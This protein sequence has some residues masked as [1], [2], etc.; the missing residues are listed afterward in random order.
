MTW[1]FLYIHTCILQFLLL[2]PVSPLSDLAQYFQSSH[3]L[4][5][6]AKTF[7]HTSAA[8]SH[9]LS[10]KHTCT[11]I[12]YGSWQGL[13]PDSSV[14]EGIK[15][16][17]GSRQPVTDKTWPTPCVVTGQ[18]SENKCGFSYTNSTLSA[19]SHQQGSMGEVMWGRVLCFVWDGFLRIV[20]TW[21][22]NLF[23]SCTTHMNYSCSTMAIIIGLLA[24]FRALENI[25][26]AT[27][28][29][30]IFCSPNNLFCTKC[31]KK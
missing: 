29:E 18:H 7:L 30:N 20:A 2:R 25:N 27:F 13:Q 15:V 24:V 31:V 14:P 6:W 22:F 17:A 21:T 19:S 3:V 9:T 1:S 8:Y 12:Y 5:K 23:C 26:S 4:T 10:H 28:N 16:L 11:N